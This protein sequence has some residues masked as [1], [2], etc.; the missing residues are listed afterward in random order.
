MGATLSVRSAT[1][2]DAGAIAGIYAHY[3]ERSVVT[4]E[5]T[6]PD[7]AEIAARIGHV[8]PRYPFLVAE[9]EG[10]IAGYAY[11]G[12]LYERP[13]YR[14]A[15]ET[16][17]YV[18]PDRHRQGVGQT[19]YSVLIASLAAQGFQTAIG[20]I[21]LPNLASVAL[22]EAFG[23]VRCGILSRVGY[24]QGGWHDVGIYQLELG[25]RPARPEET[26]PFM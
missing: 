3:V 18:A 26:R 10:R 9:Q 15:A 17:V 13:A 23:F 12:K 6:P 1:V 8:L 2:G 21:T 19:L 25:T 5:L 4:F 16:T 7:A 24:K 11:A 20:K 22:H 14:W